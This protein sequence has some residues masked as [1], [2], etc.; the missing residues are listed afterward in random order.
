M[1]RIKAGKKAL[2][3]T[4]KRTAK[5]RAQKEALKSAIKKATSGKLSDVQ[6]IIDKA[7]KTGVIHAN[8]AGRLKSRLFKKFGIPKKSV[9]GKPKSVKK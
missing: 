4:I 6:A 8:K 5:N 1:I 7:A 2:R 3:Q 9:E